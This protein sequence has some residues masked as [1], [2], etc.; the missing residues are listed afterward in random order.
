M[1]KQGYKI[2]DAEMHVMEPVDLWEKYIDP[3]FKDRAPKRLSE[4][5]WDICTVVEGEVMAM[6]PGGDWPAA[7]HISGYNL[8]FLDGHVKHVNM[9]RASVD[10][11]LSGTPGVG[12]TISADNPDRKQLFEW[13]DVK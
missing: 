5:R 1:A 11:S 2:I 13:Q 9:S 12:L 7:Y 6:I 3:A 8:A 4:R 10:L